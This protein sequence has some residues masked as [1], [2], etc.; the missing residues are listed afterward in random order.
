MAIV[1]VMSMDEEIN[2]E[3]KKTETGLEHV[4]SSVHLDKMG[5]KWRSERQ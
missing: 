4:K 3:P 2:K 5:R 1:K